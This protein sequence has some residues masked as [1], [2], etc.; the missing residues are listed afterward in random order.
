MLQVHQLRKDYGAETVLIHINF[1]LNDGEHVGLVGPNGAG[2][3]TLL[4]CI[5]GQEQPDGGT[6]TFSPRD[7][8][9]GYLAQ[10]FYSQLSAT[11]GEVLDN[12]QAL[13][14]SAEAEL[15][16]C[17]EALTATEDLASALSAYERALAAFDAL[18]G[19]ERE[20]RAA[21]VLE[22]LGLGAIARDT[23]VAALSGG[24]KTRL[25]LATLLLREPDLLILDEPT[26][27]LDIA[28]LEWLESFVRDYPRA[29]LVVAHDRAFLD[30]T[31]SRILALDSATHT[32]ESYVGNY[33]DYTA[34]RARE[35]AVQV[36]A[37]KEQQ[38]YIGQVQGDIARMKGRSVRLENVKT[39]ANNPDMKWVLGGSQTV[40]GK[41][42]R[43][44]KA[45]E[46]KL[47]RYLASDERVEKPQERW[48]LKLD[49]GDPP[50]GG[51][52]VLSVEALRFDYRA[53][54]EFR[55][56]NSEFRSTAVAPEPRTEN[57]RINDE[58]SSPVSSSAVSY[59]AQCGRLL[60]D[61]L[62][63]EVWHGERVA[64]LG[65]NGTGKSTLL[66]LIAGELT[67]L[68]GRIRLG[69]NI[70]VGLLGQEHE[71]LN[72]RRTVLETVLR[73]RAID[74]TAARN[75]L[76]FFLFSGDAVFRSVGAC[77][78]GERSRL[79]LAVLV[80]RGCNLLLLDEPLNHLDIGAREHFEAALQAYE[81][82]V[83]V[84]S[85]DRAFVESFAE[86][87]IGFEG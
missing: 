53:R 75:F 74:G 5:V 72:A 51:R 44:A 45:R 65:P 12:A 15:Q 80:L 37:Y 34:A 77:S 66:K 81:G 86:R 82:T 48:G 28:A 2:K 61:G 59:V 35:R 79:Q 29:V 87:R 13:F 67:P 20:H 73:E 56:Q 32:L 10:S 42:A 6:I 3:S 46:R 7:A 9:I 76:H 33:S 17:T 31:V 40:A 11:V 4:R 62:S 55:S 1:V 68:S 39:P 43:M 70:R 16:R 63:F 50:P 8:V 23:S 60:I 22:G 84:V 14:V 83:I 18:G 30:R 78:L 85:H 49:F 64:L 38:E 26:N 69:A 21:A 54:E 57:Q 58:V 24:Q 41:L 19:Y 47:E 27:H 25:G 71:L 52:A 36:A